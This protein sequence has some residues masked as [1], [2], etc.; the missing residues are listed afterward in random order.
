MQNVSAA[1]LCSWLHFQKLWIW[2][3]R[4]KLQH[5]VYL[6]LSFDQNHLCCVLEKGSPCLFF[7]PFLAYAG[8]NTGII[9]SLCLWLRDSFWCCCFCLC[10]LVSSRKIPHHSRGVRGH[11]TGN[12]ISAH[13]QRLLSYDHANEFTV[14]PVCMETQ[15]RR[16]ARRTV[17]PLETQSTTS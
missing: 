6:C 14:S 12:N 4:P 15:C 7:L 5:N 10:L 8:N 16:A 9:F 2:T 3:T 11:L 13:G 1:V 17:A